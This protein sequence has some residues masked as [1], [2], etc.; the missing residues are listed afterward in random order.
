MPE[1]P[2]SFNEIFPH[3]QS[4]WFRHA[5]SLATES[6]IFSLQKNGDDVIV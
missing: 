2:R 6:F 4:S 5:R 1:A 3:Y